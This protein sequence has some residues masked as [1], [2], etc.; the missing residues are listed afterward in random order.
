MT[1]GSLLAPT[2][3]LASTTELSQFDWSNST[4]E[5]INSA[6]TITLAELKQNLL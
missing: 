4:C 6:M 5:T 1:I 2:K 3:K